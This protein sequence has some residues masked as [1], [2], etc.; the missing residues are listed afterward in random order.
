MRLAT[1]GSG[2]IVDTFL[3]AVSRTEGVFPEA[4]YSRTEERAR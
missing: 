3:D 1:I 2:S 4:V